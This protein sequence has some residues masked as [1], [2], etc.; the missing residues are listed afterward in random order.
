MHHQDN[1][2]PQY[3]L[4][5]KYHFIS[6]EKQS[7]GLDCGVV[8]GEGGPAR[9]GQVHAPRFEDCLEGELA[10]KSTVINSRPSFLMQ[11]SACA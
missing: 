4:R 2:G 8:A 3:K 9:D 5:L 6:D 1:N 10:G 7:T 11:N